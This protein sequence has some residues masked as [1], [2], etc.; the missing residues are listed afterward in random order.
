MCE[1]DTHKAQ[2]KIKFVNISLAVVDF[3]VAASDETKAHPITAK[4]VSKVLPVAAQLAAGDRLVTQLDS[5]ALVIDNGWS[6]HLE[7]LK[8]AVNNFKNVQSFVHSGWKRR[9]QKLLDSLEKALPDKVL[10]TSKLLLTSE[11]H[12]KSLRSAV[13]NVVAGKMLPLSSEALGAL[14]KFKDGGGDLPPD[15]KQLQKALIKARRSGKIAISV[16][17]AIGQ[18][19]GFQPT[20]GEGM[21]TYARNVLVKC[22]SKG[23]SRDDESTPKFLH[24]FLDGMVKKGL[25]LQPALAPSVGAADDIC[26]VEV[27]GGDEK[28][29]DVSEKPASKKRKAT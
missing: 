24:S 23:V 26:A 29:K 28:A 5:H 16:D 12:L 7:D 14:K 1:V 22:K 9:G 3:M 6:V 17:W 25:A 15:L 21:V 20:N 19:Q 2:L 8:G 13:A 27:K 10:L 4:V 18:I 11:S